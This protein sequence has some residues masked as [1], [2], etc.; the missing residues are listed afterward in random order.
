[1]QIPSRMRLK[2]KGPGMKTRI[3]PTISYMDR[4]IA[5]SLGSTD[6]KKRNMWSK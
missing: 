3:D 6:L 4:E 1:M 5:L 2:I